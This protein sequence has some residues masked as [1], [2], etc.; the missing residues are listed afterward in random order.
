MGR[1]ETLATRAW[2]LLQEAAD[3]LLTAAIQFAGAIGVR[4]VNQVDTP[5]R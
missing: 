1:S 3:Q 5:A 2:I 4:S